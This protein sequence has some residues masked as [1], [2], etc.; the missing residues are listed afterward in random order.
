MGPLL[1]ALAAAALLA[2]PEPVRGPGAQ[3]A[4]DDALGGPA[5]VRDSGLDAFGFPAPVL[6][7]LQRPGLRQLRKPWTSG[8]LLATV[9]ELC[10][11]AQATTG[12]G[13]MSAYPYSARSPKSGPL[14]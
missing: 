13:A 2:A 4:P 10:Q 8:Q 3:Q 5:T 1:R 11:R 12:T 14:R 6:D 9:H 7:R